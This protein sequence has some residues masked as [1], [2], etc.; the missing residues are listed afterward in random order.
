[1]R[2]FK[3]LKEVDVKL[4]L[5]KGSSIKV[6]NLVVKPYTI[7]EIIENYGYVNYMQNLQWI[8]ISIDDFLSSVND[9]RKIAVLNKQKENL[10]TFDFYYKLGGKEILEM[11]IESMKMIFRTDD[12]IALDNGVIAVN[13]TKRGFIYED[14]EGN[15]HYDTEVV[16]SL[17]EDE[18]TVIHRDNFD[19]IVEVV[20]LQNY[21]K[22][23][24]KDESPNP[25]DEQTR[26]LMEQM[27]M[28]RKK[29]AE[30]KK[31]QQANE[32]SDEDGIDISDIISAV[33]SKSNS[34][35]KFNVWDFTLYQLYDEYSRLELIDNYQFSIQ[36]M[37]AG[38]EK[39]DLKHWSSKI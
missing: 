24:E 32:Y 18:V 28:N 9:E 14:E 26:K 3:E 1:M 30:K 5:L 25:V 8:S 27:E 39:V 6:E 2:D 7:G 34:L 11:L 29:V 23:P 4:L 20:K 21:L 38:A 31:V 10:K 19:D 12:V 22:K 36:A 37:M 15:F 35:N 13:F 17:T 16:E 33:S